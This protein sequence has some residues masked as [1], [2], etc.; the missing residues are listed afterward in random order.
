[1]QTNKAMANPPHQKRHKREHRHSPLRS[2]PDRIFTRQTTAR[3][4]NPQRVRAKNAARTCAILPCGGGFPNQTVVAQG[5]Q[6]QT[7]CV[8]ARPHMGGGQQELPRVRRDIKRPRA[9]D[10]EWTT[11][12]KSD[13]PKSTTTKKAK[14]LRNLPALPQSRKNQSSASTTSVMKPNA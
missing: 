14:K 5:H 9:Q 6:K 7:I 1:M 10:E 11:I 4:S 3:R 13:T 2:M 8:M 12:D